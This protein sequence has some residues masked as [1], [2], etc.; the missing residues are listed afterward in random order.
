MKQ[1][2]T[3]VLLGLLLALV[4]KKPPF[5][6]N[7]SSNHFVILVLILLNGYIVKTYGINSGI[8]CALIIIVLL[9]KKEEF[10]NNKEGFV[11]KIQ[12]WKPAKFHGP[13][14]IDLDRQIK[15]NSEKANIEATKQLDERTNEGF[16]VYQKQL[17]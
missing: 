2:I 7:I 12:I 11:P 9:D 14:Q 13:C 1:F 5:L 17:Y 8:V 10:C 4:Y 6:M 15:E 16:Q 3:F